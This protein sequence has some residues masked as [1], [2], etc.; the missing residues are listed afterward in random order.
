MG[1]EGCLI[2]KLPGALVQDPPELDVPLE[3][4]GKNSDDKPKALLKDDEE[5]LIQ[6]IETF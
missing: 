2:G 4:V 6:A 1:L 5:V 3:L